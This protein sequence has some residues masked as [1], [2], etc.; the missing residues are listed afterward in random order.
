MN[1]H[2]QRV[3]ILIDR[4]SSLY[5]RIAAVAARDSVTVE[6]VVDML[7]TV[8]TNEIIGKR[9]SVLEKKGSYGKD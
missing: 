7:V 5:R 4:D 2:R 8:G 1:Y 9:L 6:S 3:E